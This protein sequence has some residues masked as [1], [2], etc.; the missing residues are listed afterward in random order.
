MASKHQKRFALFCVWV[1][2]TAANEVAS[3]NDSTHETVK[4]AAVKVRLLQECVQ[5]AAVILLQ[6]CTCV[7]TSRI[8]MERLSRQHGTDPSPSYGTDTDV[9]VGIGAR[10]AEPKA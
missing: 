10:L 3:G 7:W 8:V 1:D 2:N 6:I 9:T 4:H 5:V